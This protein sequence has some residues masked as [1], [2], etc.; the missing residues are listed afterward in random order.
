MCVS[1]DRAC[2]QFLGFP[3][4]HLQESGISFQHLSFSIFHL[5]TK[6]T[7]TTF[8]NNKVVH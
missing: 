4:T 3:E 2:N 6:V 1:S 8:M 7:S 5:A